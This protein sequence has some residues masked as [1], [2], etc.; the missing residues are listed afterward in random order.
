[1]TERLLKGRGNAVETL[2]LVVQAEV[3]RPNRE[4]EASLVGVLRVGVHMTMVMWNENVFVFPLN[5]RKSD[6]TQRR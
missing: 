2:L 3:Q 6:F 1:M 4:D 5:E